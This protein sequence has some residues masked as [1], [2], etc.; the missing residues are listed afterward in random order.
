MTD[1]RFLGKIDSPFI[2]LTAVMLC[3]L[4][5]CWRTGIFINKVAFTCSNAELR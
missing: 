5:G 3:H 2:S 4:L 1:A